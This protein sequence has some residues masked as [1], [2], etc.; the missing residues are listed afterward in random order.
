MQKNDEL[1]LQEKNIST[2]DFNNQIE[3]FKKGFP[4]ID[5]KEAATID[6]GIV[7]FNEERIGKLIKKYNDLAGEYKIE[8]FVPA[9]GAASRMFKSLY[10]FAELY[11][12]NR[13]GYS[14]FMNN[15]GL[16]T[17]MQLFLNISNFAFYNDLKTGLAK[18]DRDLDQMVTYM[19]YKDIIDFLLENFG[20]NYGN[21][22][23][24]LI[25][26]HKYSDFERV[27]FEEHLVEGSAYAKNE[28]LQSNIHFTVSK[29]HRELFKEK[30][31]S[32]KA[33]YED[34]YGVN[35]N[36]DFSEQKPSTDIIAVDEENNPVRDNEGNLFFRPGGHGALIDNLNDVNS[37]IIFIK[38]ID[39]VVHERLID[40]TIK[41]KK[42]L[43]GVLV[44]YKEKINE[45][46]ELINKNPDNEQLENISRFLEDNKLIKEMPENKKTDKNYLKSILDRP[47]RVCGMVE[48]KGEPGG[49]P[50]WV[51]N[52]D[53]SS[54]LQIVEKSQIDVNNEE[55]N[56]I[57]KSST[58]FNPVDIVCFVKD[59]QDKKYN[60]KNYVDKETGLITKKSYNGKNIK[61]QELP[62]LWNGAMANWNTV[63]VEVPLITFNPV[64]TLDDLLRKEHQPE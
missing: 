30:F 19:A 61:A 28:N 58:H 35:F 52:S 38:N 22:P 54:S 14:D 45:K 63:F 7:K 17:V 26:F 6:N 31:K 4:F 10:A 24:G 39:N 34:K 56:N 49:G 60:L 13:E 18:N 44:D 51:K 20:L 42:L 48:N 62:G 47:L 37:D 16:N 40:N 46:L 2:E 50:F 8:K 57:L 1:L 12:G 3:K 64:K 43:A 41:Y 9:S 15:S 36:I 27:P 29:Q 5:I 25:K 11:S 53:G 59:Y 32:V 23:K 55:K 21:L 33:L